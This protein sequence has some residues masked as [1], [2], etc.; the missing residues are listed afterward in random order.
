MNKQIEPLQLLEARSQLRSIDDKIFAL[1]GDRCDLAKQIGAIK[2]HHNMAIIDS[3]L[4]SS[5]LEK[6]FLVAGER[7]PAEL[8]QSLTELLTH[9]SK[10]IQ[11]KIHG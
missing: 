9:W 6:N 7:A 10:V 1:V 4:E 11:S 8:I 3:Q 5:N 2:K